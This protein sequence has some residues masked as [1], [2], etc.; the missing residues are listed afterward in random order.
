MFSLGLK[1]GWLELDK[2]LNEGASISYQ[3]PQSY[4]EPKDYSSPTSADI[5]ITGGGGGQGGGGK[6]GRGGGDGG[7]GASGG[8]ASAGGSSPWRLLTVLFAALIAASGWSAYRQ[9]GSTASLR[10][11]G[12][13]AA[14]LLLSAALMGGRLRTPAT[15]LALATSLTLGVYMGKGYMRSRKPFPQGVFTAVSLVLSTGYASTLL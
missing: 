11:S 2:S 3:S 1:A 7:G 13:I 12:L 4:Q 10:A 8:G 9:K 15:L 5:S 14:A 6:G